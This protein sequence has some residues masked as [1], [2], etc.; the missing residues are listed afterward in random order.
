MIVQIDGTMSPQIQEKEGIKGRESLKLPTEY[1][2][3]NVIVI[4]KRNNN[5]VIDKH[6][7]AHYGPRI[8]F[9]EYVRKTGIRMGQLKANEVVFLADGAKHNWDIQCTNFPDSTGIL[10]F[11]HATEH[12]SLFCD[13][14]TEKKQGD[15]AYKKWYKMLLEGEKL[16]FFNEIKIALDSKIS[17]R[18]EAQKHINYFE[19]NKNRMDYYEYKNKGYPI[20]SGMVEGACKYIVGKRFKGSGMRWKKADNKAILDLRLAILNERL[21]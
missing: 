7:G 18:S 13:T 11:Y 16:Q 15:V 6:V 3:C 4:E 2:E 19:N 20:G 5:K 21:E 9:E 17:N 14:F 10:D 8:G 12:L 1:K